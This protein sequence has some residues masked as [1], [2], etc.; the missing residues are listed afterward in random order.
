MIEI[1]LIYLFI[2]SIEEIVINTFIENENFIKILE[3]ED[4]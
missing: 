2:R 1:L 4:A 3:R